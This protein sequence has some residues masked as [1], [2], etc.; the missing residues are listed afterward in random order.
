M[1]VEGL[2]QLGYF[3]LGGVG[4]GRGWVRGC[5]LFGEVEELDAVRTGLGGGFQH[6][7]QERVGYDWVGHGEWIVDFWL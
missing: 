4:Y 5:G 3:N 2:L 6:G 7:L 1:G